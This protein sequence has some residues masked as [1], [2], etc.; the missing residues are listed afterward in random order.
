MSEKRKRVVVTMEKRLSVL[1]RIDKGESVMKICSELNVGKSTVNDWRR[2][3]RS[4]EDF[5]A[6]MESDKNLKTRCTKKKRNS[7]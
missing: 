1:K 7:R 6:Q 4:I 5:C 2:D 3:R